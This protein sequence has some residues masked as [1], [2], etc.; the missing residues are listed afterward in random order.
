MEI[1][2]QSN[3]ELTDSLGTKLL[4]SRLS[5]S[6]SSRSASDMA[7]RKSKA[8]ESIPICPLFTERRKLH[9]RDSYLIPLRYELPKDCLGRHKA[10]SSLPDP[11]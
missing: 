4:H 6:I 2:G 10:R 9:R 7:A 5:N 8:I 1:P 3:R 11:G